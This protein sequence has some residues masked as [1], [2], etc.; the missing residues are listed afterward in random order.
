MRLVMFAVQTVLLG[1]MAWAMVFGPLQAPVMS[2]E[3]RGVV[4]EGEGWHTGDVHTPYLVK[5]Y[6]MAQVRDWVDLGFS[7]EDPVVRAA[8]AKQAQYHAR[9]AIAATPTNGYAWAG[10]GWAE[11]LAGNAP[12]AIDAVTRARQWAPA[13]PQLALDRVLI[14]QTWWLELDPADR[15]AMLDDV[16]IA[17]RSY[18]HRFRDAVADAPLL[19]TL[20]QLARAREA[21]N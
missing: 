18:G 8:A 10:L 20:L 19:A 4:A 7:T 15:N 11:T 9:R 12:A 3:A 17:S 6:A 14:L 2:V 21:A 1:C 13:S 5:T 16:L